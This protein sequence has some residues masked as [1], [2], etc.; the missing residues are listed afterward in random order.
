MAL[1]RFT[2]IRLT[3]HP[4]CGCMTRTFIANLI[5]DTISRSPMLKAIIFDIDDTLLDWEPHEQDWFDY[6]REHLGIVYDYINALHPLPSCETFVE[7]AQANTVERWTTGGQTL[8][9]PNLGTVLVETLRTL[10]VPEQY[11]DTRAILTAYNWEGLPGV[12]AFPEVPAILN[13][14][15]THGVRLGLITNAYHPMWMREHELRKL[16]IDP[17]LFDSRFSSA[18][19]GYLK[20]H[21]RI[22]QR[23]LAALNVRPE[24]AIFVGDNPEADIAGAQGVGMRAVLRVPGDLPFFA[25]EEP[26]KPDA[27]LSTLESLPAILDDWYPG[28]R[29]GQ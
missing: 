23:S 17:A 21:P 18:D 11:L 15:R 27:I 12:V 29:N 16:G 28:W 13:A 5:E 7:L 1:Y 19:I 9:A 24:E 3:G 4:S 26:V 2:L 25:N 8:E 20:P 22:F 14:F 10:G 6:D